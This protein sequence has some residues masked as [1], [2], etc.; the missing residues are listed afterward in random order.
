[1]QTLLLLLG[2]LGY[3]TQHVSATA[4]TY[5]LA[6]SEKACFFTYVEQKGAKVAFYF[7]VGVARPQYYRVANTELACRCKPVVPLMSTTRS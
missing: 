7:A 1:M 3:L 5:K 6:P 2:L 4:L